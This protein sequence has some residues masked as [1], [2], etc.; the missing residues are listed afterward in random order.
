M[1]TYFTQYDR[2]KQNFEAL[3]TKKLWSAAQTGWTHFVAGRLTDVE[4]NTNI[5]GLATEKYKIAEKHI[6]A[7]AKNC[8]KAKQNDLFKVHAFL[9]DILAK[10]KKGWL[11]EDVTEDRPV[12]FFT[13]D[14][15]TKQKKYEKG[16][17]KGEKMTEDGYVLH[18][19][20][21]MFRAIAD[22]IDPSNESA[23]KCRKA[24]DLALDM[25][26]EFTIKMAKWKR[27]QGKKLST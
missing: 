27:K 20:A 13:E 4:N 25:E 11:E 9:K 1:F 12:L 16:Q 17:H 15:K 8:D 23:E 2:T 18:D 5:E 7:Y 26:E 6:T 24:Y 14:G 3:T 19:F 22:L 10:K 21:Q